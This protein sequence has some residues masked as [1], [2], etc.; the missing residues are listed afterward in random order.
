MLASDDEA[1]DVPIL[2][3]RSVGTGLY[4]QSDQVDELYRRAV[5]AGGR[6]VIEPED[7][8]W[9]TRRARVLDPGGREWS[10]GSYA[11]GQP[12]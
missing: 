11:P 3:G 5:G 4:L 1:Y 9:G 8:E 6:P 7:T 10:L 12:G 2:R